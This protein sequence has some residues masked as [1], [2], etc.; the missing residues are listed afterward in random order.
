[1]RRDDVRIVVRCKSGQQVVADAVAR[2][3]GIEVA[4]VIAKQLLKLSEV[5]KDLYPADF[6]QWANQ[7]DRR[8]ERPGPSHAGQAGDARPAQDTVQDG[9]GLV[10]GCVSRD[11]ISCPQSLRRRLQECVPLVAGGGLQ[12]IAI[13]G[14]SLRDAAFTEFKGQTKSLGNIGDESSVGVGLGAKPMIEM[15]DDQPA[16]T[17]G[18]QCCHR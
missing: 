3:S 11:D 13:R 18:F 10:V 17:S 16:A 6:E 4:R 8:P 9:F 7:R 15:G 12:T 2:E 1:M 5:N 14:S